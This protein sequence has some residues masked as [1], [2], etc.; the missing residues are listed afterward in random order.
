MAAKKSKDKKKGPRG[1]K[2]RAKA[3]LEQVWG[4]QYD[5]DERLASKVRIGKSRLINVDNDNGDVGKGIN[6]GTK[7]GKNKVIEIDP[8]AK[9]RRG[10]RPSTFDNFL[11]RKEKY[12]HDVDIDKQRRQFYEQQGDKEESSSDDDESSSSDDEE[13][14]GMN[15][16]T[17]SFATLLKRISGPSK[18]HKSSRDRMDIDSDG[19][20]SDSNSDDDDDDDDDSDSSEDDASEES[21]AEL[22]Q[23]QSDDDTEEEGSG[24]NTDIVVATAEDPYEQHFSR[25]PL[26]QLDSLTTTSQQQKQQQLVVPHAGNNRKVSTSSILKSSSIDVQISGPLLDTFDNI[27]TTRHNSSNSTDTNNNGKK[28]NKKKQSSTS[29]ATAAAATKQSWNEFALGPYKHVRQVITRN[30]SHVNNNKSEKNKKNKMGDDDKVIFTSLQT[31]LYPAISRYADVLICSENRQ[32]SKVCILVFF[33]R[34]G[35]ILKYFQLSIAYL[36]YICLF[37]LF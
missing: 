23:Q 16:G 26:P 34:H 11:Q 27:V 32:V 3:K 7:G 29:Q 10:I 33:F 21:D 18:K 36:T 8:L 1:K 4:E 17:S 22:D 2:A 6:G 35:T 15:G 31:V 28:S 20:Y 37:T 24:T 13:M 12:N 9:K 14:N 19:D 30:W 5:E 25:P